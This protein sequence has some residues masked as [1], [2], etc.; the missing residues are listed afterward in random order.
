SNLYSSA[1]IYS[2]TLA[3]ISTGGTNILTR[4]NYITVVDPP[5]TVAFLATPSTGPASLIVSFTNL[6]AGA[7][8][9]AWDFG[10]GQFSSD[11]DPINTYANAG[12]YSV[13]LA[14]TGAGGTTSLTLTNYILVTIPPLPPSVDFVALPTNGFVPLEVSFSN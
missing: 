5:P 9:Y 2:V 12:L 4:T 11:A 3:A 1:G 14:A 10:D 8:N 6:S 7:T 13:T